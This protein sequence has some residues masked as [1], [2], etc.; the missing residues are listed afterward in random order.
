MM[1][2]SSGLL[3]AA[4]SFNGEYVRS[5]PGVDDAAVAADI[6]AAAGRPALAGPA[7][8]VNPMLWQPE[9]QSDL[10][11]VIAASL[12]FYGSLMGATWSCVQC[13]RRSDHGVLE[14]DGPCFWTSPE[15]RSR[16]EHD[17]VALAMALRMA[18]W[19]PHPELTLFPRGGSLPG[20]TM[21]CTVQKEI[22]RIARSNLTAL[23]SGS[24]DEDGRRRTGHRP[25]VP[26]PGRS[27]D[28]PRSESAPQPKP[29]CHH[30]DPPARGRGPRAGVRGPGL[31][32]SRPCSGG[33][34]LGW[35]SLPASRAPRPRLRRRPWRD[36]R[37]EAR[38]ARLWRAASSQAAC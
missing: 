8:R 17:T 20:R 6:D 27:R 28:C 24:G 34:R 19:G 18:R 14:W 21:G 4:K 1:Q 11:C 23:V 15:V 3:Y 32:H 12:C 29:K 33:I 10:G 16:C 36:V 5:A 25:F 30:H 2:S 31:G 26:G 22:R 35:P 37:S 7:D 13:H 38:S 9:A